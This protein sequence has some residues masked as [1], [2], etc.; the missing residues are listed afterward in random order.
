MMRKWMALATVFALL[1]VSSVPLV[2][3][4]ACF[5]PGMQAMNDQ[6]ALSALRMDNMRMDKTADCFIECAC[7]YRN[8]MDSLPHLLAP[9]A[10]SFATEDAVVLL[11][12]V[13]Q[14]PQTVFEPRFLSS[15]LP[16]PRHI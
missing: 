13:I 7:K 6:D 16:P 12:G 14:T 10:A 15:S 8:N 9:H 2:S 3:A 1:T 4:D 11:S 5:M